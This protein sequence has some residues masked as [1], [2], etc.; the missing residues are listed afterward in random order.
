MALGPIVIAIVAVVCLVV[1][2]SYFLF[3]GE[4]SSNPVPTTGST[5]TSTTAPADRNG[6]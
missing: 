1:A 2:L 4:R 5:V 6:V 3:G